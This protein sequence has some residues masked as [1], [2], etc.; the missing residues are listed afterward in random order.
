MTRS[1]TA[2]LLVAAALV[3]SGVAGS[4]A[5]AAPPTPT[6]TVTHNNGGVQV[7]ASNANGQP[8]AGVTYD[9][10]GVCAGISL[11]TTHCVP[12]VQVVGP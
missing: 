8:I 5:F 7:G 3:A 6:V 1:T 10:R 2:K 4:S 11:Q 9:D 12:P